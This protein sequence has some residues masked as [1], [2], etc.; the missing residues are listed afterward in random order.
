M[1][2]AY[3]DGSNS[4]RETPYEGPDYPAGGYAIA[5]C[6]YCDATYDDTNLYWI[7]QT[8]GFWIC[9]ECDSD[10]S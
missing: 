2:G 10:S 8:T 5:R 9:A 4:A 7:G 1:T 6:E 3:H